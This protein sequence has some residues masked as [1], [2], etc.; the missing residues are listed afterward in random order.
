MEDIGLAAVVRH[1]CRH[2][3]AGSG[4]VEH[5]AQQGGAQVPASSV[6]T[7]FDGRKLVKTA[8]TSRSDLLKH[9]SEIVGSLLPKP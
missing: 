2:P 6:R 9:A 8:A 5:F 3:R 7:G 1:P 4:G